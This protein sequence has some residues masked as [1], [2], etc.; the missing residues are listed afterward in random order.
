MKN[1]PN[2]TRV[3][4]PEAS[5][6]RGR[7]VFAEFEAVVF[8]RAKSGTNVSGPAH[9]Y[10]YITSASHTRAYFSTALGETK[11]YIPALL[12]SVNAE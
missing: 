10:T 3:S 6:R 12:F 8:E 1:R 11:S 2:G 4:N 9:N 7:F 5:A